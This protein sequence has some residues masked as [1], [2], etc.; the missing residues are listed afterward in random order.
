[1]RER[2]R[3]GDGG[4]SREPK[5]K[6]KGGQTTPNR[7]FF[8]GVGERSKR[9]TPKL[10]PLRHIDTAE[11]GNSHDLAHRYHQRR[12]RRRRPIPTIAAVVVFVAALVFVVA[13]YPL[14]PHEPVQLRR[15][16]F[17]H[18]A[19]RRFGYHL[20][21]SVSDGHLE[22]MHVQNIMCEISKATVRTGDRWRTTQ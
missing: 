16:R 15:P 11:G 7:S 4:M 19:V 20:G 1:M 9:T 22:Y 2:G 14:L 13:T 17:V 10:P 8:V 21:G 3:E 6:V 5:R 12:R 18:H